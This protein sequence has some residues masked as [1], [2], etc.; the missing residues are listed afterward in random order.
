MSE[1]LTA[2]FVLSAG[3]VGGAT[4]GSGVAGAQSQASSIDYCAA[5][6]AGSTQAQA[7]V[8]AFGAAIDDPQETLSS[9]QARYRALFDGPCLEQ[10]AA[11]P[12]EPSF[13]SRAALRAWWAEGG[14]DWLWHYAMGRAPGEPFEVVWPPD[15]RPALSL[16]ASPAEHRLRGLLC[17]EGDASCGLETTG[18]ALR[19]ERAFA[20]HAGRERERAVVLARHAEVGPDGAERARI[21]ACARQADQTAATTRF[22][23][24]S[25]CVAQARDRATALPVGRLRA[26]SR[27]WLVIRGRRGHYGFCDEVRAYDLGT[28]AAY[29][30]SSCSALALRTDGSVHGGATD[31]ARR[32]SVTAGRLPVDALREAAWMLLVMEEVDHEHATTARAALPPSVSSSWEPGLGFGGSGSGS[33]WSTSAQTTL[34]WAWVDGDRALAEGTLTWPDSYRAAEDHAA[35]LVRVAEAALAPGC[36]PAV[37]PR[38]L[39]LGSGG[40]GVSGIDAEPSALRQTEDALA[41]A[42]RGL[43]AP[44]CRR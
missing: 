30:A 28:G 40:G 25:A 37:L 23:A 20:A 13:R 36:A 43:R 18:W 14:L 17:A 1:W 27:G 4:V 21:G 3:A 33:A 8:R 15:E 35:Q 41:S 2:A 44:R 9:L 5:R 16:E 31:A 24:W 34:S 7:R 22:P 6:S 19:A 32:P 12:V 10:A 38:R 39:S 29:V 42:L 26:P 11:S